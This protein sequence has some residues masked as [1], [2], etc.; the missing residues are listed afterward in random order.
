MK[1]ILEYLYNTVFDNSKPFS[2]F[3]DDDD[4]DITKVVEIFRYTDYLQISGLRTLALNAL[5]KSNFDVKSVGECDVVKQAIISL[6]EVFHGND[7]EM[8]SAI[9]SLVSNLDSNGWVKTKYRKE[10]VRKLVSEDIGPM[11]DL[12]TKVLEL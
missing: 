5:A 3:L 11:G 9:E 10:Q 1:T 12:L 6:A 4:L 2:S 8:E 7:G